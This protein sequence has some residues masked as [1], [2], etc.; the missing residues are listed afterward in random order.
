MNDHHLVMA[1]VQV[2]KSLERIADALE[3]PAEIVMEEAAPRP[4]TL[5]TWEDAVRVLRHTC[6][7]A[8]ECGPGCPMYEWC[9]ASLPDKRV[10]PTYWAEPGAGA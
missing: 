4:L 1:V 5:L 8:P 7:E 9:Q 3:A 2:A 10:A 6:I